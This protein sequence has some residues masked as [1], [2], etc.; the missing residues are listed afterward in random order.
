MTVGIS[1]SAIVSSNSRVRSRTLAT[2][3]V[4]DAF[5]VGSDSNDWV[6]S[7]NNTFVCQQ[8]PADSNQTTLRPGVYKF[9]IP[10]FTGPNIL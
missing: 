9:I 3:G 4:F 1:F 6:D 8:Q 7:T 5:I 2:I 10:L